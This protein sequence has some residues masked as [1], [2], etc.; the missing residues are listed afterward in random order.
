MS[1]ELIIRLFEPSDFDDVKAVSLLAFTPIYDSF[2]RIL[3]DAIFA[4]SHPDWTQP[5]LEWMEKICVP[6]SEYHPHV[7]MRGSALVGFFS[8]TMDTEKRT[9]EF[10]INFVHPEHQN[11]GIGNAM[12][13]HITEQMRNAG[14]K[15]VT[16]S[17]GG[18][19]SHAPARRA[20][21]KAGF[22]GL[23]ASVNMYKLL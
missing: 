4:Y 9:G 10:G 3:G 1:Q 12:Y 18:D 8:Y 16:V 6:N 20:Y 19:P 14:I 13:A 7:V 15:L 21:E 23:I 2:R 11:Q 17:T 22:D 5:H